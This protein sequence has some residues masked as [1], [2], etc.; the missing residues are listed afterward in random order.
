[1]IT[2]LKK[3]KLHLLSA[4]LF[5]IPLNVM[6]NNTECYINQNV[7]PIKV[8]LREN[9]YSQKHVISTSKDISG[10]KITINNDNSHTLLNNFKIGE[11]ETG[12]T[13]LI[14]RNEKQ[15][16]E[17]NIYN[18]PIQDQPELIRKFFNKDF[19]NYKSE[20]SPCILITHKGQ[21]KKYGLIAKEDIQK[22]KKKKN[23]KETS[24]KKILEYNTHPSLTIIYAILP[25]NRKDTGYLMIKH[26]DHWVKDGDAILKLEVAGRSVNNTEHNDVRRLFSYSDTPQGVYLVSGV[27]QHSI[28][29][30]NLH[31]PYLDVDNMIISPGRYGYF[32]DRLLYTGILPEHTWYEYWANEFNLAQMMGRF[33]LRIH[34]NN[35]NEVATLKEENVFLPTHGCLNLGKNKDK[36]M[37]VLSNLG[38]IDLKAFPYNYAISNDDTLSWNVSSKIGLV[39]LVIKDQD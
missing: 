29:V 16:I 8:Y 2:L 36:F 33:A 28:T 25:K 5:A 31:G 7:T 38:V 12:D 32:Y 6:A 30:S 37:Q 20:V 22:L 1:M 34:G 9:N 19:E 17:F 14:N 35:P 24:L 13:V 27:M 23:Y 39:F 3:L 4:I 10:K 15:E 11:L 18:T 26:N 21:E